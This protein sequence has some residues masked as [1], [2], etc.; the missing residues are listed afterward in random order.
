MKVSAGRLFICFCV[1]GIQR[2]IHARP[3]NNIETLSGHTEGQRGSKRVLSGTQV[4][5]T[6]SICLKAPFSLLLRS[7]HTVVHTNTLL[8]D[9]IDRNYQRSHKHAL[10]DN[11]ETLSSHTGVHT[12]KSTTLLDNIETP[13]RHI[14]SHAHSLTGC[15]TLIRL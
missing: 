14:E 12:N 11:I 3:R 1:A 5:S 7:R 6:T 13:S 15:Q 9:S 2:V 10:L 8:L 4:R